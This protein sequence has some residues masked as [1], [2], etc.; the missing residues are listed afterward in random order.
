MGVGGRGEREVSEIFFR[1]AGLFQRAQH[2]VAE[3]SFFRLA[4][5]FFRQLLI[6]ARGD[7]NFFGDLDFARALAG[8]V[9]G[10]AVGLGLHAV[11]G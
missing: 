1:V 7:V 8:A 5:N 11:D 3:D 2:Q 6:H 9:V 10:A 4:R